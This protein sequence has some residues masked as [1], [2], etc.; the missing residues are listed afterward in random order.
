[1]LDLWHNKKFNGHN[2][3][4]IGK[5][6][7]LLSTTSTPSTPCSCSVG[8]TLCA[9]PIGHPEHHPTYATVKELTGAK[10]GSLEEL[11]H[12][13]LKFL[14]ISAARDVFHLKGDFTK[15]AAATATLH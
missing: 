1:M 7:R 8:I 3:L 14:A 12:V 4:C 10:T 13:I 9:L 2:I 5:A 11:L 6:L 15:P